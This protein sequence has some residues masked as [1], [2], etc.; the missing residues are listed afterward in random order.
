[1]NKQFPNPEEWI[2][3]L[4]S[5][6]SINYLPKNLKKWTNKTRARIAINKYG[7]FYEKAGIIPTDIYFHDFH[8]KTSEYFFYKTINRTKNTATTYYVS[9]V[10]K[11]FI[12]KS[13]FYFI[14]LFL[15]YLIILNKSFFEKVSRRTVKP[16]SKKS[17]DRIR[18]YLYD[19]KERKPL[20]LNKHN[21]VYYIK[22]HYLW[23]LDNT[24]ANTLNEE[25]FHFR[26]SLTSV[27]NLVSIKYPKLNILMLGVD[28]N[29]KEYFFDEELEALFTKT[30]L[31]YDWSQSFM[32]NSGKHY[33][34]AVDSGVTI[35]DRF[36]YVVD[37][38]HKSENQIFAY[39]NE[40]VAIFNGLVDSFE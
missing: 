37:C 17:H 23:D 24:W 36:D 40:N 9:P 1:M 3:V 35:F 12:T 33:S 7:A 5:G 8:D 14:Y 15:R 19:S 18:A 39:P 4:G 34:A 20:L 26:G 28:L 11:D 38:L 22:V 13:F 10:T 27:L 6:A 25:L 31:G 2:V 21:K 16:F 29:T 30:G 32:N